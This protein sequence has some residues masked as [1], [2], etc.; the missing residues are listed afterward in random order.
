DQALVL[1]PSYVPAYIGRGR[2]YLALGEHQWALDDINRALNL[3]PLRMDLYVTRGD[4]YYR[5]KQYEHALEDYN[6]AIDIHVESSEK[7]RQYFY[8]G[9]TYVWL[10]NASQARIDFL[11]SAALNQ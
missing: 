9:C 10:K 7:A 5:L 4:A 8:R 2:A 11:K 3:E 1:L 6:K